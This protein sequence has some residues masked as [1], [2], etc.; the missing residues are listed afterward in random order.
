MWLGHV[1]RMDHHLHVRIALTELAENKGIWVRPRER[2]SPCFC[3]DVLFVL[4]SQR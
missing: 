4:R 3:M 2:N 1:L